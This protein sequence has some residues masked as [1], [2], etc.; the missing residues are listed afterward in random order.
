[1]KIQNNLRSVFARGTLGRK[2]LLITGFILMAVSLVFII[3]GMPW[4]SWPLY[5]VGTLI[6][7][8]MW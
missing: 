8:F 4:V 3:L 6:V 5:A 7:F 1:V 2:A